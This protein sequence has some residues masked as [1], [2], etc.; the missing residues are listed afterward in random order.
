MNG[1]VR[2]GHIFLTVKDQ[3]AADAWLTVPNFP[4]EKAV[5]KEIVIE[6]DRLRFLPAEAVSHRHFASFRRTYLSPA[7]ARI[8]FPALNTSLGAPG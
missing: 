5:R 7:A 1:I 3:A 2:C 8:F 6:L 4:E